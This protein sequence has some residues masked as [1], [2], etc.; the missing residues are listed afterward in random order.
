MSWI[1]SERIEFINEYERKYGIRL[2]ENDEMLPIIHFIFD[3][4]KST[5]ARLADAESLLSNLG[6][7]VKQ[8]TDRF[9]PNTYHFTEGEALKWQIGI[10]LKVV[11]IIAAISILLWSAYF[12]WHSYQ[13]IANAK[14]IIISAPLLEKKLLN[15]IQV[16]KDGY[17]FLEFS[18]PP[19]D[20]SSIKFF[21][22][23]EL[24]EDGTVRIYL[25]HDQSNRWKRH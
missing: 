5:D 20:A 17:Y 24:L 8:S 4:G 15:G 16:N 1:K 22:E 12:W 14:A 25:T 23:Y 11:M 18:R 9:I 19:E 13:D 10:G 7:T 21:T 2:A 3:A 6:K